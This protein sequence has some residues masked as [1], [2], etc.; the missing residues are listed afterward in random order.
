MIRV[1]SF[2]ILS[3]FLSLPMAHG[4]EYDFDKVWEDQQNI[5]IIPVAPPQEQYYTP[6]PEPPPPVPQPV[7]QPTPQPVPQVSQ[8]IERP[9]IRNV[10]DSSLET[11]VEPLTNMRFVR[12]KGGCFRMGSPTNEK[13]RGADERQHEACVGDFWVGMYEVTQGQWKKI[14]GANPSVNRK[15]DNYPVENISWKNGVAFAD[16]LSR[17]SGM[18]FRLPTEAE[19]EFAARASSTTLYSGS[20]SPGQIAWYYKNSNLASHPVGAKQSNQLGLYDMSGNVWEWCSDWY[21]KNY[22][23]GSR[24]P[25]GPTS[26]TKKVS[27]GGSWSGNPEDIRVARREKDKPEAHYSDVGLRLV[28]SASP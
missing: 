2:V 23:G 18:G 11:Y 21:G 12:V 8:P 1:L 4:W 22:S 10:V 26:G 16:T 14:M 20:N 24:N 5:P 25:Q 7:P 28:M 27:R 19:W 17:K 6:L 15:G 9:Q 3:V 13:G